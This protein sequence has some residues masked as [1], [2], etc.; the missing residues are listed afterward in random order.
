M[1]TLPHCLIWELPALTPTKSSLDATRMC[2][3]EAKEWNDRRVMNAS[4]AIFPPSLLLDSQSSVLPPKV[5]LS[6][7]A[8]SCTILGRYLRENILEKGPLFFLGTHALILMS[9]ALLNVCA[10]FLGWI[11]D[12]WRLSI[13]WPKRNFGEPY[14]TD[15]ETYVCAVLLPVPTPPLPP[16]MMMMM[17]MLMMISDSIYKAS[18]SRFGVSIIVSPFFIK[19]GFLLLGKIQLFWSIYHQII[20]PSSP[21]LWSHL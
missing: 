4:S 7:Y 3:P 13:F 10:A 6:F 21:L 14:L 5:L 9:R 12:S 18:G 15:K 17:M 2:I 16:I 8:L 19:K 1:K 20:P 11:M